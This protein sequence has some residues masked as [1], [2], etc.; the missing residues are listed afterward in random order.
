MKKTILLVLEFLD[1]LY[2]FKRITSDFYVFFVRKL[3][4]QDKKQPNYWF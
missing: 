2:I 1:V 3:R 4:N